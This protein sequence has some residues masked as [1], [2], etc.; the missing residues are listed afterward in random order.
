MFFFYKLI[1][2]I[3]LLTSSNKSRSLQYLFCIKLLHFLLGDFKLF[4]AKFGL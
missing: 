1:F 4:N 3:R 2:L